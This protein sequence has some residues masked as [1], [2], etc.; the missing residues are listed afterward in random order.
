MPGHAAS[1]C[2][3]V[4]SPQIYD[5][6]KERFEVPH[7]HVSSLKS[8]P[9][10][11]ISDTLEMTTK[12]FGLIV[13]RKETKKVVWVIPT[14]CTWRHFPFALQRACTLRAEIFAA[15]AD[16]TLNMVKTTLPATFTVDCTVV[17][18]DA[19]NRQRHIG[20]N[21]NWAAESVKSGPSRSPPDGPAALENWHLAL[22]YHRSSVSHLMQLRSGVR[23]HMISL[24][25][26]ILTWWHVTPFSCCVSSPQRQVIM[27]VS[28]K[29]TWCA[30]GDVVMINY[31][32]ELPVSQLWLH[33]TTTKGIKLLLLLRFY[34]I[35]H[36]APNT[37]VQVAAQAPAMMHESL[38]AL[39]S[40]EFCFS[41]S[42]LIAIYRAWQIF[43][44]GKR[45]SM[46]QMFLLWSQSLSSEMLS[47]AWDVVQ[48]R[49][50]T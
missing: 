44:Q 12:P 7:E 48:T 11:P 28:S 37:H 20:Q 30:L 14:C 46:T 31:P 9:T 32:S 3:A 47:W 16:F 22:D 13:R 50:T 38:G 17:L 10:S 15:A 6:Q 29:A 40:A 27:F 1:D 26:I 2:T 39:Q 33:F 24:S 4:S 43:L 5:V 21:I 41:E 23:R 19:K 18:L 8:N 35:W 42:W 36:S 34:T 49:Q 45:L 25:C